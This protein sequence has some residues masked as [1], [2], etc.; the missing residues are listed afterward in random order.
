MIS[1]FFDLQFII[2][3][4]LLYLGT[5]LL[6][7]SLINKNKNY[8]LGSLSLILSSFIIIDKDP[9]DSLLYSGLALAIAAIFSIIDLI[10]FRKN[11]YLFN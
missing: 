2:F 6:I 7:Y 4:D 8:L 11:P 1:K 10:K 3:I 5:I 9:L